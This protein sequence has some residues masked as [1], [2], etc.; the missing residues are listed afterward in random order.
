MPKEVPLLS[1]P[2]NHMA[3]KNEVKDFF[4]LIRTFKLVIKTIDFYNLKKSDK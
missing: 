4:S 1:R 3:V 2:K